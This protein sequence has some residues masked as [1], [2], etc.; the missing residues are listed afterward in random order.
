MQANT[1][2][3]RFDIKRYLWRTTDDLNHP[4]RAFKKRLMLLWATQHHGPTLLFHKKELVK[5]LGQQQQLC[6]STAICGS[7]IWTWFPD[8]S[9][10][11]I[12]A[13]WTE[14]SEEKNMGGKRPTCWW[15]YNWKLL[16]CISMCPTFPETWCPSYQHGNTYIIHPQQQQ[17]WNLIWMNET[18]AFLYSSRLAVEDAIDG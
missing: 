8:S 7:G 9:C 18:I 13:R 3:K 14:Y 16:L 6:M 11:K 5:V 15:E 17:S 10:K 1:T 4:I 2:D 12:S